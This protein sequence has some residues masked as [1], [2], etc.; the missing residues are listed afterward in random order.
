MGL[1]LFFSADSE[2]DADFCLVFATFVGYNGVERRC[3]NGK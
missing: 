3:H 2:F 1:R